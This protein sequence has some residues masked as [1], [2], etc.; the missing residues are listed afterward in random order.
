M[1]VRATVLIP[2]HSHGATLRYAAASVLAQTVESLEV[3]IVLDGPTAETRAVAVEVAD[4]DDRVRLFLNEKGE[5]HGEAHRDVAL[6]QA[7]GRI[8]CYLS[9]DDMWFP[10]HVE[11]LDELLQDA[12]LAH[13]LPVVALP[14]GDFG[15]PYLGDLAD[16][17][18]HEWMQGPHNFVPLSATGH[19]LQSYRALPDGWS[20]APP[21]MWTDLH[22]WR[23]FLAVPGLRLVTGGRP[24]LLHFPSSSRPGT[25][26]A[27][28][29][30]EIE[31]WV[32]RLQDPGGWAELRRGATERLSLRAAAL[33]KQLW[34][35][36]GELGEL[37]SQLTTEA[38]DRRRAQAALDAVNAELATVLGSV[39]YRAGRRL[40]AVPLIGQVGRWAAR[41]LIGRGGR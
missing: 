22:M 11:Y 39:A 10:D 37:R 12:D 8:V 32:R 5:R 2:T 27:D 26:S 1:A 30:A 17:W 4:L 14:S 19:T 36:T 6:R 16:P 3:F 9:D 7:S 33:H 31:T 13:S 24:T 25:D 29:L 28:R 40:A 41:A 38:A 20:P 21:G 15:L 18:Y 23:K 35:A 34:I